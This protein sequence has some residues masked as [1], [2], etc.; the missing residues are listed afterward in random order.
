M[1]YVS[2]YRPFRMSAHLP[3]DPCTSSNKVVVKIF[4]VIT[5]LPPP[6]VECLQCFPAHGHSLKTRGL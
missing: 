1:S 3:E 4:L 6:P 5:S 2:Q